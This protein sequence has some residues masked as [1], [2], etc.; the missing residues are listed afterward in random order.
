[1]EHIYEWKCICTFYTTSALGDYGNISIP[2]YMFFFQHLYCKVTFKTML[3][4][5]HDLLKNIRLCSKGVGHHGTWQ[6]LC[7]S[8]TLRY[9]GV[10]TMSL[11][12]AFLWKF[13][14]HQWHTSIRDAEPWFLCPEQ[15]AGDM[16]RRS[17]DVIVMRKRQDWEHSVKRL[18]SARD[19]VRFHRSFWRKSWMK[20]RFHKT[21]EKIC[22]KNYIAL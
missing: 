14:S 2:T 4:L 3:S 18:G 13:R 6:R 20:K 1:M 15:V 11:L 16:R 9:H 5:L 21:V 22:R 7:L 10:E 8:T 12:V 19:F 17:C